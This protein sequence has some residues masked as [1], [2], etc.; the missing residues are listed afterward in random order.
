MIVVITAAIA[1]STFCYV[2][3]RV[4]D[5]QLRRCN[6]HAVFESNGCLSPPTKVIQRLEQG[7]ARAASAKSAHRQRTLSEPRWSI[8]DAEHTNDLQE[9]RPP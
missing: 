2:Q 1:I 9:V 5:A 8:N 6:G 7:A 3:V 4:G